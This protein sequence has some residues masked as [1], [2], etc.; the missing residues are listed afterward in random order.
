MGAEY[1]IEILRVDVRSSDRR[2]WLH[3]T[4]SGAGPAKTRRREET[5]QTDILKPQRQQPPSPASQSWRR[6]VLIFS[7][8]GSLHNTPN[9]PCAF[10]G[11][12]YAKGNYNPRPLI[13]VS[14]KKTVFFEAFQSG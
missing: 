11:E 5:R 10:S 14:P 6:D 8:A 2:K 3:V 1:R 9:T 13:P 4:L 12:L 7:S